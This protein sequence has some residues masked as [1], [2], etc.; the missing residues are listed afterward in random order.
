MTPEIARQHILAAVQASIGTLHDVRFLGLADDVTRDASFSELEFD[1]LVEMEFCLALEEKIGIRI[2]P[3]DLI[4][5]PSV[6]ALAN[7]RVDP[8][9]RNR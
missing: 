1:S 2:D 9:R 4:L 6:N 5:H 3:A 7:S 8:V